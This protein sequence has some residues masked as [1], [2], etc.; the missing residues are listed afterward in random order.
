L[1]E[2]RSRDTQ[3]TPWGVVGRSRDTN[4]LCARCRVA[5]YR[6]QACARRG[7]AHRASR[8][9]VALHPSAPGGADE[10]ADLELARAPR[11][12]APGGRGAFSS[13]PEDAERANSGFFCPGRPEWPFSPGPLI[14][15]CNERGES[16]WFESRDSGCDRS[17]RRRRVGW[18]VRFLKPSRRER[19]HGWLFFLTWP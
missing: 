1:A 6:R 12:I 10:G 8:H 16:R 11:I 9:E 14:V 19:R 17:A 2:G 3:K 18:C 15:L 13:P 4:G 7:Q 5:G